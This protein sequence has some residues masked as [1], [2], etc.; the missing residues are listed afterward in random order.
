MKNNVIGAN[1][2]KGKQLGQRVFIPRVDLI[3]SED[4]FPVTIRRRQ[5]PIRPAFAMT[6]NK[7]QGQTFK[8]VGIYLPS[9]VFSHGQLYVAFSRATSKNNVRI[10]I[11]Q[12]ERQGRMKGN[13]NRFSTVNCV[14]REIFEDQKIHNESVEDE[15]NIQVFP[16]MDIEQFDVIANSNSIVDNC[17]DSDSESVKTINYLDDLCIQ[18]D[19]SS[20]AKRALKNLI[21]NDAYRSMD[22]LFN[23]WSTEGYES[24]AN[25]IITHIRSF[26]ER[27]Y[28]NETQ[29]DSYYYNLIDSSALHRF[30]LNFFPGREGS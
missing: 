3:P 11:Q 24:L 26:P 30:V 16:P 8:R 22:T 12:T 9:P 23:Q 6:I 29:V 13:S 4:E 20:R 28:S 14:Y 2:L 10:K 15:K 19:L 17:C 7:S 27:I 21:D 18:D 25:E 5:F 1:I